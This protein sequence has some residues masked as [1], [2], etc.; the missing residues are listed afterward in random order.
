MTPTGARAVST[1][2]G[3]V[4]VA[5]E[6]AKP[7]AAEGARKTGS[8]G[9][10]YLPGLDGLRALAV[11]GVLLYHADLP[12]IP[13]GFLGVDVFFV[14]SGF[15]ITSLLL[16]EFARRGG[17][18]FAQF[19]L[20]RARR[21]LPALFAVLVVVAVGAA[22]IWRDA[23]P[24]VRTDVPAAFFYVTNWWYIVADQS[25]FEAI[26]RPALLQHL[27]SL[28][29]EEQFYFV[30]PVL[31]FLAM[32]W[33]GRR[34]VL[35][36]AAT[37]AVASTLWMTWL[38]V[39]NGY[40]IVNDPSRV[41]FGSDTHAMGLLTGAALACTWRP[42][43]LRSTLTPQAT[44]I[45]EG[46]GLGSLALVILIFLR[47]GEYSE[48][49]YR[50]GFA[51]LSV[52][53]AV[54][55]AAASHPGARLGRWLSVQPLQWIG[56]RSYGLYLWH[57]P[58]FMVTRPGLDTPIEGFANLV[59][60][61]ALTAGISELSYRYLEMPVRHGALGRMWARLRTGDPDA[62]A[63][64]RNRFAI[65]AAGSVTVV[66]LVGAG[67]ATAPT[68]SGED[69]LAAVGD[70]TSVSIDDPVADAPVVPTDKAGSSPASRPSG[71][72]SASAK[73]SASTK[74][75]ASPKPQASGSAVAPPAS[76][77]AQPLGKVTAIGDSVLLGARVTLK[78][79]IPGVQ[80]DAE[81]GRQ[82]GTVLTRVKKIKAQGK[83]GPVVVLHMGTNG[84]VTEDQ[85]RGMLTLL[86]DRTRVVVVNTH[87][88]RR[89]Q[90][91]NNATMDDIVPQY[92]NARLADWRTA[93]D[94]RDDFFVKDGV[95]L[96]GDG[97]R[98]YAELI[99]DTATAP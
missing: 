73:P 9:L 34:G 85:L 61:L 42:G 47:V 84:V 41:Y 24:G 49:L 70:E 45:I 5:A 31:A 16:E 65:A 92:A 1:E 50:G 22:F 94:G 27:W 74:P 43:R 86:S 87:V 17:I 76:S 36:V 55:V 77:T 2:P 4:P 97:M 93:A 25:Y 23:A 33:H 46:V 7:T 63:R 83:L 78:R 79:V 99:R 30:W 54:L 12:W 95:H 68:P 52:I 39:R 26:G 11:T 89:W 56:Q 59:L 20:R 35:I 40:P 90:D 57:W 58:V 82:A 21:L 91:A 29:V 60:R 96:T 28:A 48:P 15:L 88:P 13:G 98:A 14:L 53:T 69:F 71:Q 32:R 80:V 37:G 66:A 72:P 81:V 62:R 38:S 6:G 8:R 44:R 10:G 75:Q 3:L 19:Y 67:L 51:V 18:D 64:Q